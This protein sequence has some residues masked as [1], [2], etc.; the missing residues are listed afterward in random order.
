MSARGEGRKEDKMEREDE[1]KGE[2][3]ERKEIGIRMKEM[4]GC[5]VQ[6]C[7]SSAGIGSAAR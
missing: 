4:A 7:R 6:W 3:R 2:R 1:R 5:V